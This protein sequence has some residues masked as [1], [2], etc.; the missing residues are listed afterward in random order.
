MN[1]MTLRILL[2]LLPVLAFL[3]PA[4][5]EPV[6]L[7]ALAID[8]A[9]ARATAP[10]QD[11]GVVYLTVENAG[12]SGDRLVSASSPAARQVTLHSTRMAQGMSSMH[13]QEAFDVPAGG[14]LQLHPDGL[15]LM[16]EGLKAPLHEGDRIS[17]T[18]RFEKSGEVSVPVTVRGLDASMD[19][20]SMHHDMH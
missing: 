19:M 8:Q 2:F 20:G 4:R 7:K 17:L 5:A 6:Q 12:K 18:L 10:G 13:R 3:S 15:H 16:L 9:Y 1:P 11:V 14:T